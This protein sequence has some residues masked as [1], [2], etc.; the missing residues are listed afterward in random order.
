[1]TRARACPV[2]RVWSDGRGPCVVKSPA[3]VLLLTSVRISYVLRYRPAYTLYMCG[4][5]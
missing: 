1:M 4:E 5:M 3:L 2:R